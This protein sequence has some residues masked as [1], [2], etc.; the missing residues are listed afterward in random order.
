MTRKK[1][2]VLSE[3]ARCYRV[4]R[5]EGGYYGDSCS[6]FPVYC[7]LF[8]VPHSKMPLPAKTP[9]E[10][11]RDTDDYDMDPTATYGAKRVS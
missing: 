4:D 8:P 9:A 2:E 10:S 1:A 7:F 5:G 6:L 3:F 11:R